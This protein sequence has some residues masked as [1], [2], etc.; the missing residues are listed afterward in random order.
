VD[1]HATG[2]VEVTVTD[3]Y[4]P[5][6][7]AAYGTWVARPAPTT[8]ASGCRRRLHM[9]RR[10]GPS[11]MADALSAA[12]TPL[13]QSGHPAALAPVAGDEAAFCRLRLACLLPVFVLL[14]VLAAF[15]LET[16][17]STGLWGEDVSQIDDPRLRRRS[18]A[19]CCSCMNLPFR[20]HAM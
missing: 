20:L 11:S 13:Q 7:T 10:R 18:Y 17:S 4:I 12:A 19:T 8:M 16:R 9:G 14:R 1:A 2:L 15:V 3:R 6:V 5:L